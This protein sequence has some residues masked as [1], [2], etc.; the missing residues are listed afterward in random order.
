ME[1]KALIV[2][3]YTKRYVTDVTTQAPE[4][5][6]NVEGEADSLDVEYKAYNSARNKARDSATM[7]RVLH[8]YAVLQGI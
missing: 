2:S 4:L 5:K 3:G 7:N 8:D 6:T 1:K